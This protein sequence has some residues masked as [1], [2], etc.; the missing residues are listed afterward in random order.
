MNY[1]IIGYIDLAVLCCIFIWCIVLCLKNRSFLLGREKEKNYKEIRQPRVYS[2]IGLVSLIL[3]LFFFAFSIWN[4]K[5]FEEERY[6]EEI[7]VLQ[8]WFVLIFTS[9]YLLCISLN[10]RIRLYEDY[11]THTNFI[12]VTH[13]YKYEEIKEKDFRSVTRY[14]KKGHYAFSISYFQPNCN[15]L[16]IA[17][18]EYKKKCKKLPKEDIS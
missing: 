18:K 15:M 14:Y 5:D 10:W 2:Y 3:F 11:F 4:I 13:A 16:S 9:V 12:G 17:L 6:F 1:K 8:F 7:I